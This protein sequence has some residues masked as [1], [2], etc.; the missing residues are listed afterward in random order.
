MINILIYS[1]YLLLLISCGGGVS[2]NNSSGNNGGSETP[3]I[4]FSGFSFKG[5]LQNAT[6]CADY[7]NNDFCDAGEPSTVTASDGSFSLNVSQQS[8]TL[9]V[10]SSNTVDTTGAALTAGMTLKAP[11]GATMVSVASTM[12]AAGATN[13][14]VATAL[15]INPTKDLATYNPFVSTVSAADRTNYEKAAL[16]AFTAVSAIATGAVSA[17]SDPKTAFAKAFSA[18]SDTA[19]TAGAAISFDNPT[20]IQTIANSAKTKLT[21][22]SGFVAGNFSSQT[23]S[24]LSNS[25]ANVSGKLKLI[26][27]LDDASTKSLISVATKSLG[28]DVK[29]AVTSGS[30]MP[31]SDA[32]TFETALSD[33]KKSLDKPTNPPVIS[34]VTGLWSGTLGSD[35]IKVLISSSG[36]WASLEPADTSKSGIY[37]GQSEVKGSLF[38]SSGNFYPAAS[39]QKMTLGITI[40]K[41]NNVLS[42]TV[43][44]RDGS[45]N[46][47]SKALVLNP[48][49]Y[50]SSASL[51]SFAGSWTET[52]DGR[53]VDLTIANNFISGN[54]VTSG[55]TY[56]GQIGVIMSGIAATS[57]TETCQTVSGNAVTNSV[58]ALTGNANIGSDGKLKI[59][60]QSAAS[61]L[62]LLSMSKI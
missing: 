12:I 1:A 34:D 40:N 45:G 28:D 8:N 61:G 30:P 25:V 35:P 56:A 16:Q 62:L 36:I 32:S 59:K 31:L 51:A 21:G 4:P 52:I 6:V 20:Q 10:I 5:P 44:G 3:S 9:V 48:A 53:Q 29:A 33:S 41:S 15:G 60:V 43:I 22:T 47:T 49:T 39:S 17:G 55:C 2:V 13:A 42:G 54:S 27:N 11:I 46:F 58:V 18:L 37:Y 7:N 24:D 26:T 38:K 23:I 19:Q 50:L 14:Q 57:L